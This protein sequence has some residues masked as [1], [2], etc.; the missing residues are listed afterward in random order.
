MSNRFMG[1]FR[2][3]TC[4]LAVSV[5]ACW[6]EGLT[7]EQ[8]QALRGI[9]RG[10]AEEWPGL[11]ADQRAVVRE[12]AEA[13]LAR[14]Q[15]AHQPHGFT[16]EV[17]WTDRE[18]SSVERYEGLGDGVTWTGHYLAA[19]AVGTLDEPREYAGIDMFLPYWMAH[20]AGMFAAE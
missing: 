6:A 11:S 17:L 4:G 16:A 14:Y 20:A 9:A 12:K 2:G 5:A 13:Y 18:R 3:V 15:A 8:E 1:G 19:L 10:E 7:G